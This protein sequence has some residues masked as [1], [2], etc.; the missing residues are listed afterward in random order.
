MFYTNTCS[1]VNRGSGRLLPGRATVNRPDTVV[2]SRDRGMEFRLLGP[3]EARDGDRELR[4]R[5]G[6]ERALLALL[7]LNANRTLALERIVD[8]PLGRRRA[9]NGAEDG[10]GLRLAPA[11]AAAPGDPA[12]APARLRPRSRAGA[13]RPQSLRDGLDGGAGG[14]RRGRRPAGGRR[15]PRGV[16]ALARARA[17]RVRNRAVRTGGRRPS[18]GPSSV[19]ARRTA[20]SRARARRPRRRSGRARS[21]RSRSIRC[22]SAFA[23]S[24]CSR[25]IDRGGTP[26]R[27]PATRHSGG[28]SPR[29]S[30]S[31]RLLRCASSSG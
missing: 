6:K 17:G 2:R 26:R 21:A 14:A 4:L 31:S 7:L 28:S 22:E 30:G 19:R 11:Q 10:A 9:G 15:V 18:R 20:R 3:L 23:P 13:A 1:P 16:V 12:D 27:S 5:G 25:S 24:T 8:E 29:S